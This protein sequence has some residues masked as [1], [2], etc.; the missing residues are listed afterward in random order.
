MPHVA[1]TLL[2][3]RSTAARSRSMG[4]ACTPPWAATTADDITSANATRGSFIYL[5][6]GASYLLRDRVRARA[7]EIRRPIRIALRLARALA[8]DALELP[9]P[10]CRR[11]PAS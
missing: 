3:T 7:I 6:P 10:A 11:W 9:G 2:V 1:F 5:T 8:R 4:G